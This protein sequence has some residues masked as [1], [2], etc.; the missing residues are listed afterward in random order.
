MTELF[1]VTFVPP[2]SDAF[3]QRHMPLAPVQWDCALQ[4]TSLRLASEKAQEL[5]GYGWRCR[6]QSILINEHGRVE[7]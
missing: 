3:R 5:R 4:T 1:L 2:A 6:V 7:I